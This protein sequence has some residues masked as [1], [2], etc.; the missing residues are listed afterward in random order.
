M[1]AGVDYFNYMYRPE[2]SNDLH[3]TNAGMRPLFLALQHKFNFY[4]F[5]CQ[6][7]GTHCRQFQGNLLYF[8]YL[9]VVKNLVHE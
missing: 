4:Y 6:L 2:K 7:D 9:A 3:R 8:T 5:M 1:S